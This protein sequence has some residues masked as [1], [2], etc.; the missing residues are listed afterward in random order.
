[1]LIHGRPIRY[2]ALFVLTL[3][4]FLM[5]A[6]L[7]F[8][9]EGQPADGRLPRPRPEEGVALLA[10]GPYEERGLVFISTNVIDY[11]A[12][13]YRFHQGDVTV[14]FP[15]R[16][17]FLDDSWGSADCGTADALF[18]DINESFLQS[19]V[20]ERVYMVN[21]EGEQIFFHFRG[22]VR[23]EECPFIER[24]L[25]RYDW[26]SRISKEPGRLSLPAVVEYGL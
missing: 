3:L 26:F 17:V 20:A 2:F 11:R 9:Q 4:L 7:S 18:R 23:G 19:S 8:S 25:L 22:T 16:M 15:S 1:M 14:V 12:G 10:R 24:F 21:R 6:E 13:E 5:C